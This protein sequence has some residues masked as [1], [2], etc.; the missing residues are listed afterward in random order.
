MSP[1]SARTIE[2][3]EQPF[4]SAGCRIEGYAIVSAD[5]H[6]ADHN[7]H[8][9]DLLKN[10]EDQRFLDA[11]L[12]RADVLVHGRRSHEGHESSHQRRRLIVTRK[13]AAIA[14][15]PEL[16]N[17]ML[18]NPAG[19]KFKAACEALGLS[20]GVAAILGGPEVYSLFLDIGYDC[21]HLSRSRYVTLPGG[22]PVFAHGRHGGSADEA[23]RR[24]G[25]VAGPERTLDEAG[26]VT[27]VEWRRP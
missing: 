14:P 7:A 24:A 3:G 13:V 21:F 1:R 10:D 8:M 16:P 11:A 27:L 26:G 15:N 20:G 23:L 25:L 5:G 18:W 19:A 9:P 6:I 22:L 2:S 12:E 4:M 17:S